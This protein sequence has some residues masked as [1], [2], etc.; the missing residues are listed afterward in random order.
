MAGN[1]LVGVG[2]LMCVLATGI[3]ITRDIS[4][5]KNANILMGVGASFVSVTIPL[6]CFGN[7]IKRE[8]NMTYNLY[9]DYKIHMIN[10]H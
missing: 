10:Y 6:F 4:N 9:R 3:Y 1:I 5:Y 7:H 8:S 2:S